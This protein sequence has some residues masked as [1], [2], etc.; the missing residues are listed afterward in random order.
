MGI[1][2]LFLVPSTIKIDQKKGIMQ[3]H[4]TVLLL[5]RRDYFLRKTSEDDLGRIE[6]ATLFT[7][8]SQLLKLF[9]IR[10]IYLRKGLDWRVIQLIGSNYFFP[11]T[12]ID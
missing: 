1:Y 11:E 10:N 6:T 5:L 3:R 4:L 9:Q 2:L 8:N 7:R 12:E